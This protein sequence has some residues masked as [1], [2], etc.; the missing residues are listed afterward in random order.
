MADEK[1][2]QERARFD[3]RYGEP[4]YHYGTEPNA[5]LAAQKHLL[6]PGQKALVPGDGEGRNG[7][8]LAE[9]GLDVT[10]F[11]PSS[12]GM[13]KAGKLAAERGV[14]IEAK[15]GDLVSWN[16]VPNAF[17]VVVL[18]YVHV[19]PATRAAGHAGVWRTLKPGGIVIL[20]GFSPRQIEMKKHG[21]TGGPGNLA[22]LFSEEMMR[23]D[24]PGAEFLV[25]EDVDDDFE[26]RTH[27]GRCAL[28]RVVARKPA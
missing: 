9:Q 4:G 18:T 1:L 23:S 25:L 2:E 16:W 13:A 5:F 19:E 26:G 3:E 14:K 8:W 12:V 22:W 27:S 10:S 7:V 21:A 24:F 28:M 20:E 17:D 11:D 15:V 6:K